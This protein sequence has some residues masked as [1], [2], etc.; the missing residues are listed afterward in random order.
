VGTVEE[1]FQSLDYLDQR[2]HV[3][4]LIE[5]RSLQLRQQGADLLFGSSH[6]YPQSY[7]AQLW[8]LG[9]MGLASYNG[10]VEC[11]PSRFRA[12]ATLYPKVVDSFSRAIRAAALQRTQQYPALHL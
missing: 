8:P 5:G 6:S 9:Y 10:A 3:G 7:C 12:H 2:G 4:D 1:A 11:R